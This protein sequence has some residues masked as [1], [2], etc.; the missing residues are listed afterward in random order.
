MKGRKYTRVYLSNT[1]SLA[2]LPAKTA[3]ATSV[4]LQ[5][6]CYQQTNVRM[7]LHGLRQLVVLLIVEIWYP[8][9]CCKL[10]QQVVTSSLY[11]CMVNIKLRYNFVETQRKFIIA[12][13]SESLALMK[14]PSLR[15]E[16][17]AIVNLRDVS[18]KL[19]LL[20]LP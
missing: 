6:T 14:D 15:I 5:Q 7:R 18:T 4:I 12:E 16:S 17:F 11:D 10:F 9:A 2:F 19:Y 20:H 13:L 3:Q 1:N 8:Q